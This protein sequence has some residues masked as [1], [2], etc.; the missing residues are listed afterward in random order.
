MSA[1]QDDEVGTR[2]RSFRGAVNLWL[3][4]FVV[5]L[6]IGSSLERDLVI[7][8]VLVSAVLAYV[9]ASSSDIWSSISWSSRGIYHLIAYAGV[10]AVELVKANLNMLRYVYSPRIDIQPGIVKVTRG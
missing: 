1:G 5:W 3:I 4:L 9:F 6:F 10:F 2:S 7:A 8:G